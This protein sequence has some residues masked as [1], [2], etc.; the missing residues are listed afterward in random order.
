MGRDALG[1]SI[2]Y[3]RAVELGYRAAEQHNAKR[4]KEVHIGN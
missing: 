3:W 1:I 2:T 4:I